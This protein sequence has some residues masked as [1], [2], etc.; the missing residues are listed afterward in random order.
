[1]RKFL[2]VLNNLGQYESVIVKNGSGDSP[3]KVFISSINDL[4]NA[5]DLDN[6]RDIAT[7]I[8]EIA[9]STNVAG[10]RT[11]RIKDELAGSHAAMLF[12]VS[13]DLLC[14]FVSLVGASS[15]AKA[16]D[17]ISAIPYTKVVRKAVARMVAL[18]NVYD[19]IILNNKKAEDLESH[20]PMEDDVEAAVELL[21]NN[22]WDVFSLI[23]AKRTCH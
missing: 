7:F 14:C 6:L 22:D 5:D 19:Y 13:I 3:C 11:L 2:G 12:D 15:F 9:Q 18:A 23:N 8:K 16:K 20:A 1:M 17:D 10:S 21:K 4:Q